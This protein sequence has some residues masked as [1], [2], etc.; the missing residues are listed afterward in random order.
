LP[1]DEGGARWNQG[2]EDEEEGGAGSQ[3]GEDDSDDDSDWSADYEK[4]IDE[5][6]VQKAQIFEK[7]VD[8]DFIQWMC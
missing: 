6:A 4:C 1:R 8:N 5:A 3:D 7:S 2:G